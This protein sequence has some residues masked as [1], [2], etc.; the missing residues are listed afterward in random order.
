MIKRDTSGKGK[1]ADALRSRIV[2]EDEVAPDQ[3]LANPLNWR[4]HPKQQVDALEG[5]LREVG[6]VQRVIVNR[7]TGHVVDGHARVALAL[8]RDEK[9]IPVVYVDLSES[10]EKLVLAALDPIGGLAGTDADTLDALLG[11]VSTNDNALRQLLDDL[12][13]EAGIEL[14]GEGDGGTD[15]SEYSTKIEPPTYTPKG[16][17][18]DVAELC[19]PEKM[20]ALVQAINESKLDEKEKAFLRLAAHRHVV[21]DYHR[22]AEF[23]CHASPEAQ[24]LMESS[25][26]VIIDFNRAIEGGYIELSK[27]LAGI[28]SETGA[29]AVEDDD[30]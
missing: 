28:Y 22:I 6:W 29:G 2:G 13:N 8:R 15:L 16:E 20:T 3:L 11:E 9:T 23:Y 19:N 12:A 27:Q 14:E 5:L 7:R 4:T 17:K 30:E 24:S 26:L 1:G 21:F 18:P 10:E 25:A